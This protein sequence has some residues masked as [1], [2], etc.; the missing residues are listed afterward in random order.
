MKPARYPRLAALFA[1]LLV[2]AEATRTLQE[3][4]VT[5]SSAIADELSTR[6]KAR[7]L[8][9]LYL[10]RRL[11]PQPNLRCEAQNL[12]RADTE[13]LAEA[14]QGADNWQLGSAE[15]GQRTLMVS[16]EDKW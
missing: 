15:R 9:D 1:P 2:N 3:V 13:R 4:T 14:R 11:T 8:L 5:A 12:L 7:P 6:Q 10:V 16:L